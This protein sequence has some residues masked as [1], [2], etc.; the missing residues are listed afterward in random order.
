M[1]FIEAPGQ[2]R[3]WVLWGQLVRWGSGSVPR[4]GS[5]P[6]EEGGG[7]R[8]GSGSVPRGGSRPEEGGGGVPCWGSRP[9]GACLSDPRRGRQ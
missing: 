9:P 1:C 6:E 4:G 8:L 7:V 2:G 3:V 5:R